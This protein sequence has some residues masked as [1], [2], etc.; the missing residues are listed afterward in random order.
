MRLPWQ[1]D[2]IRHCSTCGEEW[3]VPRALAKR[4]RPSK[5]GRGIAPADHLGMQGAQFDA[6]IRYQLDAAQAKSSQA[7][8]LMALTDRLRQCPKCG[9]ED[10]SER[11]AK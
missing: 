6:S 4:Y 3:R 11:K 2:R 1:R 5:W 8:D 10:Y 7:E 9:S